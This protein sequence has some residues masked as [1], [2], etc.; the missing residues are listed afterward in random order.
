MNPI[1]I[2]VVLNIFLK[3]IFRP[4]KKLQLR[5]IDSPVGQTSWWVLYSTNSTYIVH[6]GYSTVH[7]VHT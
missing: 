6:G 1:I 2:L 3:P 5:Y 7:T 4:E